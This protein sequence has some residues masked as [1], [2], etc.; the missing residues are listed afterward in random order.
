LS[1]PELFIEGNHRTGTLVMSYILAH[2]GHPPFV[3]TAGCA[4]DFFDWSTLFSTKRKTSFLLGWQMPWLM[5][6]FAA[7]LAAQANPSFLRP[8]HD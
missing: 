3:L 4:K 5:R 2:D 7:F 8:H 6:R 1:E